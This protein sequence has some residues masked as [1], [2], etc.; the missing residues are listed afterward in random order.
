MS[1][2]HR[3]GAQRPGLLPGLAA[4][5]ALLAGCAT[6]LRCGPGEHAALLDSLYLGAERPDGSG[7]VTPAEWQAFVATQVV[8]R[9]PQGFTVIDAR[10][11]WRSTTTGQPVSEGSRVLQLVH[12]GDAAA[13]TAARAIADAYLKGFGQEAVLRVRTAACMAD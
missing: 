2:H 8:P 5:L 6:P 3:R 1:R 4:A 7:A 13:D 11:H 9:F 10:G 12:A